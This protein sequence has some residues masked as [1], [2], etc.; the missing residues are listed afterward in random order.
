MTQSKW[1]CFSALMLFLQCFDSVGWVTGRTSGMQK[2]LHQQSSPTVSCLRDLFG[3][4]WRNIQE[5]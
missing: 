4:T 3:L 5:Y 1:F 2:L